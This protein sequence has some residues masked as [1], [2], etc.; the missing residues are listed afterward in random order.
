MK[1]IKKHKVYFGFKQTFSVGLWAMFATLRR[2]LSIVCFFVPS[3]G[4]Q[5]ILYHWMSEQYTFSIKE[6][7]NLIHPKDQV[8]L[9]NLTDTVHW[10]ES[11]RWFWTD[12]MSGIGLDR[13]NYYEDPNEPTAP[14]YTLYTGFSLKWTFVV[15]FMMMFFQFVSMFFAKQA[16]SKEFKE[17]RVYN[18]CIHVFQNLNLC[19]PFVDW[20]EQMASAEEYKQRYKNTEMEMSFSFIVNIASSIS[21]LLPMWFTG[22]SKQ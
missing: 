6:K 7:Y 5:N 19:F 4:L 20:D 11:R 1:T 15:F 2:V 18:K 12:G 17:D 14:S 16:L 10:S 22:I 9:F 13:W 21:M 3:L 8:N